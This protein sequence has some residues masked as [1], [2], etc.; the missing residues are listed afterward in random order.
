MSQ[1]KTKTKT[2]GDWLSEAPFRLVL[3]SG[4]FGF[5]A[6]CGTLLALKEAG[7]LPRAA[8]GSSA[9]ALVGGAWAAGLE[10]EALRTELL[11][12]RRPDFWDPGLGAG[13]LRGDLFRDK[14]HRLLPATTFEQC[15]AELVVSVFDVLTRR[16]Q[17]LDAGPLAP[18]IHASCAVPLM[19]HPVW[20]RGRPYLDGGVTD[21]PGVEGVPAHER[22]LLH[23]LVSKSPWRLHAPR[24]PRRPGMVTLEIANLPRVSPF[25]LDRGAA[26]LDHAR[27]QT[28]QALARPLNGNLISV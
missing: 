20:I 9:G 23:H 21:R 4:F 22:V 6:H 18:A 14:L 24:P 12:L 25:H 8:A 13:L 16:T 27:A 2:L 3:S 26:A 11:A 19:F 7:L 15:R 28:H 5:F 10:P 1:T 17:F